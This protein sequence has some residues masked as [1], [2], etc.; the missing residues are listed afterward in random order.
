MAGA[1]NRGFWGASLIFL[2]QMFHSALFVL[3]NILF[4]GWWDDME[5]VSGVE[6]LFLVAGVF[7]KALVIA[8]KFVADGWVVA[9]CGWDGLGWWRQA[10]RA[11]V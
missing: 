8:T 10:G 4:F 5:V 1:R 2:G 11:P 3:V 7:L 9:V 6:Y